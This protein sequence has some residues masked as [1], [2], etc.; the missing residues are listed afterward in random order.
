M[1]AK[2][3]SAEARRDAIRQIIAQFG[4]AAAWSAPPPNEV[5]SPGDMIGLLGMLGDADAVFAQ[6]NA[7]LKRDTYADSSF[8]F[9]PNLAELRRD[10]RFMKLAAQIGLI[11]YWRSSGNWPDFCT[12]PGLPYNCQKEANRIKP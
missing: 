5:M 6:A 11:D 7:Y 3:G 10:P 12:E 8:L 2:S 4:S 9:W 1:A